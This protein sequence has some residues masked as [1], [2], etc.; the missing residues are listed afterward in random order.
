L[1][2]L[3]RLPNARSCL[4]IE[5]LNGRLPNQD[6]INSVTMISRHTGGVPV[7]LYNHLDSRDSA[8]KSYP[9]NWI[10]PLTQRSS[11]LLEY[12]I[13]ARN[14]ARHVMYQSLGEASGV[15]GLYHRFAPRTII[16][17]SL[18]DSPLKIPDRR[19]NIVWSSCHRSAWVPFSWKGHRIVT[20]DDE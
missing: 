15:H 3:F 6:L 19:N 14:I 12:V 13:R 7:V 20:S 16:R 10:R 18:T 8:D 17:N 4:A 2:S 9:P 1:G 11:E 5:G